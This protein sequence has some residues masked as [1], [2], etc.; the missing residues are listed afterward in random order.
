MINNCI[1][2]REA[3]LSISLCFNSVKNSTFISLTKRCIVFLNVPPTA[4]DFEK[5][6]GIG[7]RWK[8]SR[9]NCKDDGEWVSIHAQI[10][11]Y[12][13]C[14]SFSLPASIFIWT[15]LNLDDSL[16]T[17]FWSNYFCENDLKTGFIFS[18][19]VSLV[20]YLPSINGRIH[21]Y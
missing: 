6:C 9:R 7:C 15:T 17:V 19:T 18:Q 5:H 11:M 8:A 16:L 21:I 13:P 10:Q 14:P 3:C 12:N 2:T 1:R 20:G 4:L